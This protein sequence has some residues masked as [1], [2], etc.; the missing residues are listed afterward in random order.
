MKFLF[1]IKLS[2]QKFFLENLMN[3]I[4]KLSKYIMYMW[5]KDW[6]YIYWIKYILE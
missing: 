5:Y 1:R 3:F 4:I 2:F 6:I